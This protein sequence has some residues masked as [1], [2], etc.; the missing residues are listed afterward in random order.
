ML[1]YLSLFSGIGGFELGIQNSRHSDNLICVGYSEIDKYADSIYK[2]QF[3]VRMVKGTETHKPFGDITKVRTSDLPNFDLLVGGFPCQAF[4]NAGKRRGFDDTR[5]TLFFEIARILKDKKPKYFLLENVKGLLSHNKGNTYNTILRTLSEMGYDVQWEILNSKDH[6]VPQNRERIFL[7]G[8]FRAKCGREILSTTRKGKEAIGEIGGRYYSKRT[9]RFQ[10]L[11]SYC[12]TLSS[13]GQNSG[14]KQLIR[15]NNTKLQSKK[16]YDADG[17]ASCL[18][19]GTGGDGASTG[20]YAINE[21]SDINSSDGSENKI[22]KVNK[23]TSQ[24]QM[25]YD[26]KGIAP[27]LCGSSSGDGRATGLYK[28]SD[29]SSNNGSVDGNKLISVNNAKHQAHKVYSIDG[30]AST[31]CGN[32]GGDGGKTGLYM[33]PNEDKKIKIVGNVSNTGHRGNNVY[34]S[35]GLS[36][37]LQSE[38]LVKNGTMVLENETDNSVKT[39]GNFNPSGRGLGGKVYAESGLSPTITPNKGLGI[40]VALDDDGVLKE[41]TD[42]CQVLLRDGFNSKDVLGQNGLSRTITA[43][44]YKHNIRVLDDSEIKRKEEITEKTRVRR[45]TPIEC[46]R[47]QGF[48]DNWTLKGVNDEIIS[49]TQRYKCIGN[50]VTTN[51]ITYIFNNWDLKE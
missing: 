19:G 13:T 30:L 1:K 36:P 33:I 39:V 5:G 48:P 31:L 2:R 50:A 6:G 15:L 17:I 25:V 37:T 21:T 14:S 9:G 41:N 47:L 42:Q 24:S 16:V 27:S 38:N 26:P 29:D 46:E 51:V 23:A 12:N 7:K 3:P 20:L 34:D 32:G 35:D 8:Y 18:C 44:N 11:D 40:N 22:I 4:S 10:D 49:N 28:F 45:L 43:T